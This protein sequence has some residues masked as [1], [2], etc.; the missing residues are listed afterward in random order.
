MEEGSRDAN[1]RALEKVKAMLAAY[2]APPIDPAIDEA[3]KA[4]I[5]ERE[6]ELPE[7]VA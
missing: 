4:F 5:A 1:T 2:E 7:G 6:A 3:L